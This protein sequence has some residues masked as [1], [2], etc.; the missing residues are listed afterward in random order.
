M[1]TDPD[2]VV[3][4]GN[5]VFNVRNRTLVK[6]VVPAVYGQERAEGTFRYD[7]AWLRTHSEAVVFYGVEAVEGRERERLGNSFDAVVASR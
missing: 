4:T 7:H 2:N 6:R 5:C 3:Y 1:S